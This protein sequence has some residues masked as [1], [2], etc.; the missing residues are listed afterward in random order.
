MA[1]ALPFQELDSNVLLSSVVCSVFCFRG[2]QPPLIGTQQRQRHRIG[3][4]PDKCQRIVTLSKNYVIKHILKRISIKESFPEF[5]I[6]KA[7]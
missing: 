6:A 1:T 4:Q 3:T 2:R 7:R 5:R